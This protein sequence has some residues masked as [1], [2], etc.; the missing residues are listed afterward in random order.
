MSCLP[1]AKTAISST[2]Q[3]RPSTCQCD[4]DSVESYVTKQGEGLHVRALH[5]NDKVRSAEGGQGALTDV[6]LL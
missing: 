2:P 1:A 3:Y 6:L 4:A 5:I